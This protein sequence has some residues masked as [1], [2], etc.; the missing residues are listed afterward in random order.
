MDER[1]DEVKITQE[2]TITASRRELRV[3]MIAMDYIQPVS[4]IM[5][6]EDNV[7]YAEIR[8]AILKAIE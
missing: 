7:I 6:A 5:T 8:R 2:M 4:H 1:N 3:I